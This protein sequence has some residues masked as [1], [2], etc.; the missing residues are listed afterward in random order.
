MVENIADLVESGLKSEDVLQAIETAIAMFVD[1][2]VKPD[3]RFH[4]PTGLIIARGNSEQMDVISMVIEGLRSSPAL[5]RRQADAEREKEARGMA[6]ERESLAAELYRLREQSEVTNRERTEAMVRLEATMVELQRLRD[7][8]SERDAELERE[9]AM[10][11]NTSE[12]A[13]DMKRAAEQARQESLDMEKKLLE[14]AE[15]KAAPKH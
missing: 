4:E 8:V 5:T 3:I 12:M 13:Q 11:R 6:M 7:Q 9:R 2:K 15:K 10:L 14:E 1:I